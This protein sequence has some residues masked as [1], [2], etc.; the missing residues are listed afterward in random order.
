MTFSIN[1]AE[2]RLPLTA[3]DLSFVELPSVTNP[4][5]LPLPRVTLKSETRGISGEWQGEIIRTEGVIDEKSRVT[6]A[7][8]QVVDPYGVLGL[9]QQKELK[10]GTFVRAEI[11]G[12]RAD[13][14]VMLPRSVLKADNTVLIANQ[15]N[16][17]EVRQVTVIRAEPKVV[18]IGAGLEHGEQVIT[19]QLDAPVEGTTLT[20]SGQEPPAALD[21][22]DSDSTLTSSG[23]DQ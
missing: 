12:M 11:V 19:T 5:G 9:S 8:A 7:V 10:I 2:I 18:Y 20:I 16:E 1:T 21:E 14:V 15:D 22:P 13:D 6:Y 23:E 4:Q 3:T 17:L